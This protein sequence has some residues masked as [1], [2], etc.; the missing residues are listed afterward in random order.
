MIDNQFT[1]RKNSE[2]FIAYKVIGLKLVNRTKITDCS[3]NEDNPQ[4]MFSVII[5]FSQIQFTERKI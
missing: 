3:V 2:H 1:L 4:N 5:D